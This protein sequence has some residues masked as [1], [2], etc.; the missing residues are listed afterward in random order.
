MA[1][2]ALEGVEQIERELGWVPYETFEAAVPQDPQQERI[3]Q[4]QKHSREGVQQNRSPW[5]L[6]SRAASCLAVP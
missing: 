2:L 3:A 6:H 4:R 1:T 5:G